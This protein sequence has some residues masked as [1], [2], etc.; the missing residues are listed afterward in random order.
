MLICNI[1]SSETSLL[2]DIEVRLLSLSYSILWTITVFQAMPSP[3]G[4]RL[5]QVTFDS[6]LKMED[7]LA[8]E[9]MHKLY[10]M[11][12]TTAAPKPENNFSLGV[13]RIPPYKM[14]WN[15]LML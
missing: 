6:A 14:N 7:D 10:H 12:N 13:E 5:L 4:P 1:L 2:K 15:G 9:C 8:P 11:S 3:E